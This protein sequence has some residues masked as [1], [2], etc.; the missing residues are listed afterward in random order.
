MISQAPG[1]GSKVAQR[2]ILELKTKIEDFAQ[3]RS[4]MPRTAE[5][6]GRPSA[7]FEEVGEILSNIGYT[8]T[9]IHMAL[10]KAREENVAADSA[11]DLVSFALKFLSSAQ[12]V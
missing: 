7:V 4:N 1:V 2:I 9:E 10:K 6:A 12:A 3:L 11:E 8:A 5:P